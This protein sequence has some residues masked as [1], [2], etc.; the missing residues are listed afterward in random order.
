MCVCVCLNKGIPGDP[1]ERG[2]PGRRGDMVIILIFPLS[3]CKHNPKVNFFFLY[4][5]LGKEFSLHFNSM[6]A[7]TKVK[8][9]VRTGHMGAAFQS[10]CISCT[11][12][13]LCLCD[14]RY[15]DEVHYPCLLCWFQ[16]SFGPKGVS[17]RAGTW[18]RDGERGSD[19]TPGPRGLP[20]LKVRDS[21]CFQVSYLYLIC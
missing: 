14:V 20:G 12:S 15:R 3:V 13:M 10:W 19:G 21:T 4:L 16:G 5:T 11:N 9:N 2:M 8:H 6:S 7:H 18:G 17:G 1:G